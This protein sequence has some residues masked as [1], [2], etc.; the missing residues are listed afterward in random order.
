MKKEDLGRLGEHLAERYLKGLRYKIVA[1]NYRSRAGEIDIIAWDGRTL[2]FVEVKARS[3]FYFG[4]PEEGV[5]RRKQRRILEAARIYIAENR[6]F[7]VECRFDVVAV[8]LWEGREP[9]VEH[10]K[11]AF[12]EDGDIG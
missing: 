8:T 11:G 9:Q 2:V 1:K 10:I 7:D 3:N 4:T 5:G 12:E 6:L